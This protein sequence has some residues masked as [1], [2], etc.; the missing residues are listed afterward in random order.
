MF[1]AI[2]LRVCLAWDESTLLCRTP[3]VVMS[4]ILHCAARRRTTILH[5][6]RGD[7]ISHNL[8]SPKGCVILYA[9]LVCG[10]NSAL[11]MT[12]ERRQK[13]ESLKRKYNIHFDRLIEAENFPVQHRHTF[14]DIRYL[15]ETKF[16]QFQQLV[17]IESEQ[18]PWLQHAIH[19]AERVAN[20]A[21]RCLDTCKNED[22]WRQALEPEILHRFK[23]D[24]T[25]RS[26]HGRTWQS[27]LEAAPHP[28]DG[29]TELLEESRHYRTACCCV[30]SKCEADL[31]GDGLNPLFDEKAGEPVIHVDVTKSEMRKREK[32]DLVLGLR[33]TPSF[34]LLLM[35]TEDKC[36][37]SVGKCMS[38][39]AGF[40]PYQLNGGE[41]LLFP[42]L[43]LEAKSEKSKD[44]FSD[45]ELQT[46]FTIRTLLRIQQ[47]LHRTV[48]EHSQWHT[49][50]LVWF[51]SNRGEHW[52]ISAAYIE[53]EGCIPHYVGVGKC[54]LR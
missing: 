37:F 33:K 23:N 11:K 22:G 54:F 36:P 13:I 5:L 15:T 40:T 48:G 7:L 20:V 28:L 8:P 21:T 27:A 16:S 50:P 53:Y 46:A 1:C 4:H 18:K 51:V 14:C 39:V 19:R 24:I 44:S 30:V 12:P 42:F 52:R 26:C 49:G 29:G 38:N 31:R 17:T 2:S 3:A 41:P 25:C 43:V 34:D 6:R 47:D 10:S 9:L 32:P 35:R 45:L